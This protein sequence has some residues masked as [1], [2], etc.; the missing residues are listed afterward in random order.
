MLETIYEEYQK[1]ETYSKIRVILLS[2]SKNINDL[3]KS[4]SVQHS[5][6]RF[7]IDIQFLTA[8]E[9]LDFY[10][11][12]IKLYE[13]YD[14]DSKVLYMQQICE[15]LASTIGFFNNQEFDQYKSELI[16]KI[17]SFLRGLTEVESIII[18]FYQKIDKII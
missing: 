13:K 18:A 16:K 17:L 5:S 6:L 10:S 8:T 15:L 4:V 3:I 14:K 12:L 11:S 9:A 2:L 7:I 1:E